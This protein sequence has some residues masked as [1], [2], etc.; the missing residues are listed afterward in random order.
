GAGPEAR[1]AVAMHRSADLM[2]ALLAVLKSGAAYVPLDPDYPADR[3]AYMLAD[4]RPAVLVTA[5]G[6]T[7]PEQDT[8]SFRTVDLD[9]PRTTGRLATLDADDL[10]DADRRAPLRPSTPAY[11]IYTSGS[12]GRPKGV[13]VPHA[14]VVRLF[15]ATDH[16]FGFGADDAWTWFHSFAFDFSVWEMWGPLLHGGRLVVVPFD[17]SRSPADFLALLV[18]ERVTMLS[19][20]PSAFYQLTQADARHPE[21]GQA[22]ELRR[23][24]LAG[25]ALDLSRLTDWYAR[26]AEDA[27]LLVNMY[28][29]TETTVYTTYEPLDARMAESGGGSLIGRS[30]PGLRSYVL[31][32][33]LRLCPPGV[34]GELYVAG[35]NLARGYHERPALSAER[36][37]AD[38]HGDAGERMYRTGDLVRWSPDGRLEYLGRTDDQIK[39]RGFRIEL[40][41]IEATVAA[42]P[43]VA[44]AAVLVREDRPGDRRLVAYVVPADGSAT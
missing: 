18:R 8:P 9:D 12:T 43:A 15:S 14:N 23:I 27:P 41:E 29:P 3:V 37:V 1:V 13:I 19:Q 25:E 17:V 10:T 11:V 2:M 26:H 33:E 30:I 38:P 36:F 44:Q 6:V 28:G 20:T 34:A 24:V 31:D 39:L 22:L 16:W 32:A 21:Q 42:H 4:A 7:T 5:G 40:G 35:E